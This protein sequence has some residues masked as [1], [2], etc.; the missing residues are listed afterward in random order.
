MALAGGAAGGWLLSGAQALPP[1]QSSLSVGDQHPGLLPGSLFVP[2]STGLAGPGCVVQGHALQVLGGPWEPCRRDHIRAGPGTP[3]RVVQ[4]DRHPVPGKPPPMARLAPPMLCALL[5]S[6]VG[7]SYRPHVEA[8]SPAASLSEECPKS[9]GWA[10]AWK[11]QAAAAAVSG[12]QAR[13]R[14]GPSVHPLSLSHT[15]THARPP[16]PLHPFISASHS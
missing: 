15:H 10:G 4:Q 6:Q 3:G 2:S 13:L 12:L 7:V 1:L 8:P 16:S 14:G 11:E 9:W 5:S